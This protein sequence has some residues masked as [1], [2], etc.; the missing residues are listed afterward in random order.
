MVEG[1][2]ITVTKI[3]PFT[4][5]TKG[6]SESNSMGLTKPGAGSTEQPG[7]SPERGYKYLN[8]LMRNLYSMRLKH[9][10]ILAASIGQTAL[11]CISC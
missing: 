7:I 10:S 8:G 3:I 6:V 2:K 4:P 11:L 9:S 1:K 5:L